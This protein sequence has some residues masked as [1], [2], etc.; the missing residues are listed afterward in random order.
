MRNLK[1]KAFTLV[2]LLVVIT[3]LAILSVVAYE[4]FG[5]VTDKAHNATKTSNFTSIASKIGLFKTS[6]NYYPMPQSRSDTNLWGYNSGSISQVSNT[7]SVIYDE[8]EINS[9]TANLTAI[10]WGWV[11]FWTWTW[12]QGGGTDTQI[13]AK[14]VIWTQGSFNKKYLPKPIYDNQLWDIEFTW[15]DEKMIDYWI[16]KFV[17]AVYSR[18]TPTGGALPSTWNNSGTTGSSFEIATT[19]KVVDWE[20]YITKVEWTYSNDLFS[21]TD[22]DKYPETLLGLT[23]KQKDLNRPT[24]DVNQG[25]PYPINNFAQ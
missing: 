12:A 17:Y 25:I 23:D 16:G 7:I 11:I 22:A 13:W 21:W 20:W 9:L 19:L 6:E 14:W 18:A 8:A 10:N 1:K 5:W 3:I 15:S 24:T 4:S 2:E